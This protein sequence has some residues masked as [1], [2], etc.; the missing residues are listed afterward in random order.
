MR[1]ATNRLIVRPFEPADWP[2]VLGYASDEETMFYMPEGVF[3]EAA[4]KRFVRD[5]EAPEARNFAMEL[6][7]GGRLAGHIVFHPWFGHHT[8]EIGWVT[9]PGLQRRGFA[10]EA[11]RAVLRFGF[12]EL[13]LHRVIATCQP[14]NAPSSRVMEKL[15]MRREGLF[16]K[17]IPRGGGVWWDEYVYAVLA[18]EWK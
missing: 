11:A 4:A 9:A 10:T 2:E 17:C 1:I 8:Y 5:N 15:G 3:D 7:D 18:E 16:K 6:K 14:E 12:E 13:Q